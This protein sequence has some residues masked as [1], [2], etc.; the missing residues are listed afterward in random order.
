MLRPAKYWRISGPG[1]LFSLPW[2]ALVLT[3]PAANLTK[4]DLSWNLRKGKKKFSLKIECYPFGQAFGA[5]KRI[6]DNSQNFAP[7][8]SILIA[9]GQAIEECISTFSDSQHPSLV[10]EQFGVT[11]CYNLLKYKC[12]FRKLE[13][14]L[15]LFHGTPIKNLSNII[16]KNWALLYA[17]ADLHFKM[18]LYLTIIIII[19]LACSLKNTSLITFVRFRRDFSP[20][21]FLFLYKLNRWMNHFEQ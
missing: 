6:W 13:A 5:E 21:V 9:S 4:V 8:Q 17:E 7:I 3:I 16:F 20:A 14:H 11:F 10:I 12:K 2:R 15:E 19:I 18:Q 1:S